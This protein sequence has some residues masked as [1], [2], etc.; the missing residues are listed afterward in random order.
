M[1]CVGKD[2][3]WPTW[4]RK[5]C[6]SLNPQHPPISTVR[7]PA[8]TESCSDP[9]MRCPIPLWVVGLKGAGTLYK[10]NCVLG[11]HRVVDCQVHHFKMPPVEVTTTQCQDCKNAFCEF[12]SFN[13]RSPYVTRVFG[14]SSHFWH[15]GA[16]SINLS[17]GFSGME[18]SLKVGTRSRV[19]RPA[20][21]GGA[22]QESDSG[23]HMNGTWAQASSHHMAMATTATTSTGHGGQ[24]PSAT[25][26]SAQGCQYL[27]VLICIS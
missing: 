4:L 5:A 1:A 26:E 27:T 2:S 17:M 9:P 23:A 18:T 11:V 16:L 24:H 20:Q 3:L 12:S 10:A 8:F 21:A 13:R 6:A 7:R 15:R 19:F 14:F 22:A 25:L